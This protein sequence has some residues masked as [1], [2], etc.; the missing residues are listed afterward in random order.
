MASPSAQLTPTPTPTS[1]PTP[2]SLD[3][4]GIIGELER[5]ALPLTLAITYTAANDPN[6]L[7]GR[8]NGY[9]SKASFTDRRAKASDASDS[10]L[11]S[12][13][14]GG[15]VEVYPSSSGATGRAQYIQQ[16]LKALPLLGTE[17]DYVAGTVLV[18]VS[19]LLTPEQAAGYQ[20]ALTAILGMPA[21]LIMAS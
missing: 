17:Y 2:Q 11:E 10:S 19:G 16:S 1:A 15:S 5:A 18:R 20:T 8:P 7:L 12:V 4:A 13:D 14:L 6:H 21:E 9:Q 3:A